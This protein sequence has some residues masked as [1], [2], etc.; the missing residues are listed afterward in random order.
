MWTIL[1]FRDA[2]LVLKSVH[3]WEFRDVHGYGLALGGDGN[4]NVHGWKHDVGN[5][6]D[7]RRN[8][9]LQHIGAGVGSPL[10]HRVLR[11]GHKRQ[12]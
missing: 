9:E 4:G 2:C 7:Q 6:H 10:D 11:R 12:Q 8:R 1:F 3:L 5:G